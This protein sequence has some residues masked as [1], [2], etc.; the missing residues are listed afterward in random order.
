MRQL[1]HDP[2]DHSLNA[3]TTDD[4]DLGWGIELGRDGNVT[5]GTD[6]GSEPNVDNRPAGRRSSK[7]TAQPRQARAQ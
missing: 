5:Q 1:Q 7:R 4:R 3:Q 6:P 2:I